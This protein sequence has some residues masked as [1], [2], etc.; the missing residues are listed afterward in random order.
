L[1]SVDNKLNSIYQ[2]LRCKDTAS[3]A[4]KQIDTARIIKN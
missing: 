2:V 1:L 3:R 4:Q